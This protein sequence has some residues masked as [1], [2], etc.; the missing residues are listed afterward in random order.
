MER[1]GLVRDMVIWTSHQQER[2]VYAV[3]SAG[4]DERH[5]DNNFKKFS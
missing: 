2:R 4:N 5:S 1:M 3:G